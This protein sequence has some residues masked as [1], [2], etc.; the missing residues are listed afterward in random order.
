M[1]RRRGL[2][3]F[4]LAATALWVLAV[5][6]V[7]VLTGLLS[8]EFTSLI[9]GRHTLARMEAGVECGPWLY[10]LALEKTAPPEGSVVD[11]LSEEECD[12]LREAA[13][14]RA[15]ATMRGVWIRLGVFGGYVLGPPLAAFALGWIGLWIARGFRARRRRSRRN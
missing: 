2:F 4:C 10:Y 9:A 7:G 3:R 11:P 12:Q 13:I 1:N 5:I 8:Q 6:L 14:S 15:A